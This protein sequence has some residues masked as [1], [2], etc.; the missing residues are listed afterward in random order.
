MNSSS[1]LFALKARTDGAFPMQ[2]VEQCQRAFIA[3]D[4]AKFGLARWLDEEKVGRD[5]FTL[6]GLSFSYPVDRWRLGVHASSSRQYWMSEW[7][8]DICRT[9]LFAC[10]SLLSLLLSVRSS[11]HC[12]ARVSRSKRS[13]APIFFL[14]FLISRPYYMSLIVVSPIHAE[15]HYRSF[16]KITR[17]YVAEKAPSRHRLKCHPGQS[18]ETSKVSQRVD[19][20][21]GRGFI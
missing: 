2:I 13:L 8:V 7:P 11:F 4:A 12:R 3:G 16:N 15:T 10:Q 18:I 17:F 5:S 21:H 20:Y 1:E 19:Q 6:N 9:F 14:Y